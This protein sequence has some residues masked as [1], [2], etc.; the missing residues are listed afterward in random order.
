MFLLS[1][2]CYQVIIQGVHFVQLIFS[3]YF[4]QILDVRIPHI[5]G[6]KHCKQRR[7]LVNCHNYYLTSLKCMLTKACLHL[8]Q[9]LKCFDTCCCEVGRLQ[10]KYI[11]G[12]LSLSGINF[13]RAMLP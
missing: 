11:N 13:T 6:Q 7:A 10:G 2:T 12:N 8:L 3:E 9:S 4:L 5:A 1:A